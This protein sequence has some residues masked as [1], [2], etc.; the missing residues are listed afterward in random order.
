VSQTQIDASWT[1]ATD[2]VGGTGVAG[3]KLYSCQA[4]NT[5]TDCAADTVG[6][7]LIDTMNPSVFSYPNI[8]LTAD[9]RY[10]YAVR[11]Y[12]GANNLSLFSNN[13]CA[14]TQAVPPPSDTTPPSI[15]SLTTTAVSSSE[16]DLSWTASSDP[17]GSGVATYEIYRCQVVTTDCSAATVGALLTTVT[18]PTVTYNNISLP[19]STRYCYAVRAYD[20]AGNP[21]GFSNNSCATTFPPPPSAPSAPSLSATAASQTQINLAWGASNPNGG[22]ITSYQIYL[23]SPG[24][25]TPSTSGVPL[26]TVSGT[27]LTY[28]STGLTPNTTYCYLVT[29]TDSEALTSPPS[30]LACATTPADTSPPSIP[31]EL[32]ATAMSSSQINVSWDGST[33]NVGVVE[34]RLYRRIG[35]S[36]PLTFLTSVMTTIYSNIGLNPSTTYCYYVTA[37]DAAGNESNP[38]NIDCA[39]TFGVGGFEPATIMITPVTINLGTSGIPINVF[40]SFD[41]TVPGA[42]VA[43]DICITGVNTPPGCPTTGTYKIRMHFPARPSNNTIPDP[44]DHMSGTE[45]FTG[46]N[47]LNVKFRRADVEA[48]LEPACDVILEVRGLLKDTHTFSGTDTVRVNP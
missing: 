1:A 37:V 26:A 22:T 36:G 40:I 21:S 3:Y 9:T 42:H 43:Q 5:T 10:C 20:V 31:D 16:I 11:A 14:T 27:T 12:D 33:D 25:C 17:G 2:N 18:A 24:P 46:G 35:T 28:P 34:Y 4:P 19:A 7:L 32:E 45:I 48:R 38:S 23:C 6:T 30:T 15:P 39:T 29:A 8:G 41:Q 47:S 44:I 13:A